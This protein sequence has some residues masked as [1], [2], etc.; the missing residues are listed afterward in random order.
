MMRRLILMILLAGFAGMPAVLADP[1]ANE[2]GG[3]FARVETKTFD[4]EKFV[5]PDDLRAT[6]LNVLFLA[7]TKEQ[8]IGEYLQKALIDWQVELEQR[9][10]FSDGVL[11]WHFPVLSGPPFFV[12]GIIR[13]AM[14]KE[15]EGKVPLDQAGVLFVDDLD[16]FAAAA[17]LIVDDR[18]TIV[19]ATPDARQLQTFKGDVT[20]EGADEVAN[21]IAA[22]LTDAN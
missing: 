14:R 11:A 9:G 5:F 18:P 15:Y 6:R 20:P 17:E 8:D 4:K 13:R 12:K 19:L 3:T 16:E 10:A 1:P 22:Y 7:M 21:A 2:M